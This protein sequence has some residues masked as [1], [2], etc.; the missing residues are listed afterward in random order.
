MSDVNR[1]AKLAREVPKKTSKKL[2]F[3][4]VEEVVSELQ[5]AGLMT[6]ELQANMTRLWAHFLPNK[7]RKPKSAFDWAAKA[8][9]KKD[10]RYYLEY[11]RVTED[12]ITAT[13]GHRVHFAPNTEGLPAGYYGHEKVMLENLDAMKYPDTNRITPNTEDAHREWITV[14]L[15]GLDLETKA[16]TVSGKD[17]T[18][19]AYRI[20]K[21]QY[22]NADYL[23]DAV[24]LA[25]EEIHLNIGEPRAVVVI[26][27][28]ERQ[29]IIMPVRW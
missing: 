26:Q 15:E 16:V 14:T 28:G 29:G 21:D 6:E 13:D 22:V 11:V 7:P 20:Q 9:A 18:M 23:H 4:S 17:V 10:V 24:S 27:D 3:E 2:A 12:K 25:G 19:S 8:M 1:V 5:Q